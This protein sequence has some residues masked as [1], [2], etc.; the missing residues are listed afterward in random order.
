MIEDLLSNPPKI[1]TFDFDETL[2]MPVFQVPHDYA[3]FDDED[4]PRKISSKMKALLSGLHGRGS[5]IYL[6]TSRKDTPENK[7][8]VM[9][10]LEDNGIIHYFRDFVFTGADKSHT[11]EILKSELHFDDDE[12]EFHSL[13]K[14]YPDTQVKF[15]QIEHPEEAG[16]ERSEDNW[17][18]KS[19]NSLERVLKRY[20]LSSEAIRVKEL[21]KK[22]S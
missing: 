18:F 4:A 15:V 10:F 7:Q 21:N 2:S 13:K 22:W 17:N 20:G 5:A 19:L 9:Q 3:E 11:L 16:S 1:V 8:E 12:Y 14:D 6:V